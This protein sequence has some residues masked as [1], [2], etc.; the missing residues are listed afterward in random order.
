MQALIPNEPQQENSATEID[1]NTDDGLRDATQNCQANDS[2]ASSVASGIS[3]MLSLSPVLSG[4]RRGG[5]RRASF[6]KKRSNKLEPKCEILPP[7]VIDAQLVTKKVGK[8]CQR[9]LLLRMYRERDIASAE[10]MDK[11]NEN[12]EEAYDL[13]TP[14]SGTSGIGS[15]ADALYDNCDVNTEQHKQRCKGKGKAPQ[16]DPL[17]ESKHSLKALVEA[18]A[19]VQRIKT[20]GGSGFSID[21]QCCHHERD[22]D[23]SVTS[24][25]SSK[26]YLRSFGDAITSPVRYLSGF[27]TNNSIVAPMN[28]SGSLS[29][30]LPHPNVAEL[31]STVLLQKTVPSPSVG[32]SNEV[33][34]AVKQR[35]HGIFP[36]L[37][38]KDAPYIKSSWM[39][40]RDCIEELDRRCLAYR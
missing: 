3:S 11:E 35:S 21:P 22:A 9:L 20:V 6:S 32:D 4:G 13:I 5:S 23:F 37:S 12:D 30:S 39:F 27:T 38:L 33:L 7:Y 25:T 19:L 10:C 1:S 26:S 36:A 18:S 15:L 8:E 40:L 31:M 34:T 14:L 28:S 2:D 29:S 24:H 16:I 17:L